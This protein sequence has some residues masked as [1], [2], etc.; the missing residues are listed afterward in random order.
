M[1]IHWFNWPSKIGGADTKFVHLLGLLKNHYDI[2]VVP[3]SAAYY[4]NEW[5]P[6]LLQRGHKTALM[7]ELPD[8]LDGWAISLCNSSF[9]KLGMAKELKQRGKRIIWSSEM[10]W[11]F[12]GEEQ[13]VAD[14]LVDKVLY[15]SPTQRLALE[16]GY[17]EAMGVMKEIPADSLLHTSGM[18]GPLPWVMTGNYIDPQEFPMKPIRQPGAAFTIGRL[19]RPDPM[20]Y[21]D[22][23]PKFYERLGLREPVR[24]RVMAWS[25]GLTE[26]WSHHEFDAR[27]ELLESA[28]IPTTEFLQSLDVLVYNTSPRFQESWGRAVVEAMLSGVVPIVPRGHGHHLENLIRHGV[29]GFLC[30]TPQEFGNYARFLQDNPDQLNEMS[31]S[32]RSDAAER[33]CDPAEHLALWA[34]V[35]E[36]HH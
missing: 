21:P 33:L 32:A 27:W 9:F 18:I 6:W 16:P 14:G 3:N 1:Q 22:D 29:S 25:E 19:S 17:R 15:V 10:M 28:A 5:Y 34:K 13:A 30:D 4:Q 12:K 8:K 24:F 20:K 35:F 26:R 23:F 31:R 11:H 7:E 2:T 36:D